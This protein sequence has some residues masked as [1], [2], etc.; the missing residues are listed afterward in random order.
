MARAVASAGVYETPVLTFQCPS[1]PSL[2]EGHPVGMTEGGAS[3]ACNFFA[4]GTASAGYMR[5]GNEPL[6]VVKSWSW[7]G[8]KHYPTNFPD[9][10]SNTI[11][12]TEKYSRCEYPPGSKTGGGDMWAHTGQ[13]W[14]PVV[15]APDYAKYNPNCYGP[16]QGAMFQVKPNPFL[17]NCDWTRAAS[18]HTGLPVADPTISDPI[19]TGS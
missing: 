12:F 8:A 18:G 3:Y 5:Y 11:L 4:F 1:D 9:G 16:K 19:S 7:F 14:W 2:V 15:M 13:S 10:T 17:T 6:Y